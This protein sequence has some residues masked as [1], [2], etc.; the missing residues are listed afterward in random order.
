MVVGLEVG[1][2]EEDLVLLRREPMLAAV[3]RRTC[4]YLQEV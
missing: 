4:I 1:D 3:F 2:E